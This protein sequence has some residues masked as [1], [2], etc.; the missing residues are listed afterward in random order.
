[1]AKKKIA[2]DLS[3]DRRRGERDAQSA[4]AAREPMN[5]K[6]ASNVGLSP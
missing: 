6:L 5:E 4:N 1:M 2:E 3:E